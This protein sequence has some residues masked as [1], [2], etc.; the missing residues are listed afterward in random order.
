M[1]STLTRA[2]RL[3]GLLEAGRAA[4]LRLRMRQ[5]RSLPDA[6][7]IGAQKCG[8]VVAAG[9]PGPASGRHAAAAQ[10]SALFRP[11]LRSW[12]S[13][14]PR[15]LRSRGRGGDQS[16][17]EPLLRVPSGGAGTDACVAAGREARGPPARS[18]A[19]RLLA[20]TGTSAHGA[21]SRSSSRTPSR[22]SQHGSRRPKRDSPTDRW[23][24]ARNIS[25][26]ATSRAGATRSSSSAGS[27]SI[28]RA[29]ARRAFRRP[30][31]D[32]LGGLNE[33]LAFLGLPP[34]SRVD[35]EAR[36]TRRYPPLSEPTAQSLR[37][38]FEPHNRRL[39]RLLGRTMGW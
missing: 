34:A 21:A 27:R 30:G 31:K 8:T 24:A 23:R 39:E 1:N 5:A 35:L 9:V 3:V 7:I 22:R 13:V 29:P 15:A 36:N 2:L 10:G 38:Y 26:S 11:Q 19:P 18:R 4:E 33:T 32:P 16:R 14:V 25:A 12:R 20:P 17:C 6:V 28:P 37:E